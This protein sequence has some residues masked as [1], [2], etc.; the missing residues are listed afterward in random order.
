MNLTL[1]YLDIF[2]QSLVDGSCRPGKVTSGAKNTI[3]FQEKST[4]F[5]A[6]LSLIKEFIQRQSQNEC[7]NSS[8]IYIISRKHLPHAKGL[9]SVHN[10]Q[11]Q[12][13][14]LEMAIS[15]YP[16]QQILQVFPFPVRIELVPHVHL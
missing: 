14:H 4:T 9:C 11:G 15:E 16:S 1:P 12:K 8:K 13:L 10:A 2:F 5:I 6:N 7:I 3:Q